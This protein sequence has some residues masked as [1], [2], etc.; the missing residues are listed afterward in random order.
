MAGGHFLGWSASNGLARLGHPFFLPE[1]APRSAKSRAAA[2]RNLAL[3]R[4]PQAGTPD[5]L[6]TLKIEFLAHSSVATRVAPP[7]RD[8][9]CPPPW[10]DHTPRRRPEPSLLVAPILSG[11]G[12]VAR[13]PLNTLRSWHRSA[14]GVEGN[15]GNRYVRMGRG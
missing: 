6:A 11:G 2:A 5:R 9:L 4:A 3:T 8:P 13:N 1:S 14:R 10:L 12:G 15:G 7:L